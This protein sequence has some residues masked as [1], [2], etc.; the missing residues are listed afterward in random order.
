MVAQL[1]HVLVCDVV[2]RHQ[3]DHVPLGGALPG[4][5]HLLRLAQLGVQRDRRVVRAEDL[6]GQ[7]LHEVLEVVVELGGVDLVEDLEA[8]YTVG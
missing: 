3:R 4:A 5:H 6:C 7:P 1:G 2:V 8:T